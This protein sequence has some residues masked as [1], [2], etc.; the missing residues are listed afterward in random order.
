MT[1][2]TITP[3]LFFVRRCDDALSVYYDAL[4]TQVDMIC[5]IMARVHEAKSVFHLR[6][7]GDDVLR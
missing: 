6:S 1:R 2:T 3:E 7:L 4:G 5:G